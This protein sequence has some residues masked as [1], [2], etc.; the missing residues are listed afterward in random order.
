MQERATVSH[1]SRLTSS[2][3]LS[4][5]P[6]PP[7]LPGGLHLVQGSSTLFAIELMARI[8][9]RRCPILNSDRFVTGL[10]TNSMLIS[11]LS[12][13]KDQVPSFLSMSVDQMRSFLLPHRLVK[14]DEDAICAE[15]MMAMV[16]ERVNSAAVVNAGQTRR[17]HRRTGGIHRRSDEDVSHT[18][19]HVHLSPRPPADGVLV[20]V[21]SSRDLRGIGRSGAEFERQWDSGER[22]DAMRCDAI[23]RRVRDETT[24]DDAHSLRHAC[25]IDSPTAGL[26]MIVREFKEVTRKQYP[27]KVS[28]AQFAWRCASLAPRRVLFFDHSACAA[29]LVAACSP[30][31]VQT[32]SRVRFVTASDKMVDVLSNFSDGNL[33]QIFVCDKSGDERPRPIGAITQV[34]RDE[35]ETEEEKARATVTRMTA[36]ICSCHL[37]DCLLQRDVLRILLVYLGLTLRQCHRTRDGPH[38]AGTCTS[39]PH[40]SACLLLLHSSCAQRARCASPSREATEAEDQLRASAHDQLVRRDRCGI[41][42]QTRPIDVNPVEDRATGMSVHDHEKQLQSCRN[43]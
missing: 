36:H 31:S 39:R 5:V 33:H 7:Q 13:Y 16:K 24:M 35:R 21:L 37:N 28:R 9:L 29:L 27:E 42:S 26:W 38:A 10:I 19:A 40:R 34:R 41:M 1:S 2:H 11:L 20:D 3:F 22:R 32:P 15:A 8:G 23:P 30:L 14:V 6:V 43:E 25:D 17:R 12:Q 18:R 4:S